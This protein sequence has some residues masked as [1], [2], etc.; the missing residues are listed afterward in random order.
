MR[1]FASV[2]LGSNTVRL[3]LVEETPTGDLRPLREERRI[4]RLGEGLH[5]HGRLLEHR[6][7]LAVAT[8]KEF[9]ELCQSYGEVSIYAAATSAVRE[10]EN[11]DEFLRR[12]ETEA[13]IKVDVITWE[14][15]AAL[16]LEAVLWKLPLAERQSLVFDI[17][18]GS[19][20]F[21]LA[22]GRRVQAT[23]GTR[24]GVVR[25]TERFLTRHPVDPEEFRRLEA[26][27]APEFAKVREALGSP[28]P[29]VLVGTA[30]TVTTLAAL[31]LGIYPY[32]PEKIHGAVLKRSRVETLLE[33]LKRQSLEE[34]LQLK[35]LEKGREDLI[36][37]GACLALGAM[38]TFGC[39]AL[40]V[41][42]NGL[43]EGLLLK[44]CGRV[45]V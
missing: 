42:E 31:D 15:E 41:S 1:R 23:A 34:R 7:R 24:L 12:A 10:A 38:R 9:R 16:T 13:G 44:A 40:T 18:G 33:D 39:G 21:I 8:L 30:G 28:C 5:T 43:R 36:I 4:I 35:P 20:E 25:L 29:E 11:R 19:T 17:G 6:I 22:Q 26:F 3:L 27:L 14:E 45:R 37:V 2:D 32:D